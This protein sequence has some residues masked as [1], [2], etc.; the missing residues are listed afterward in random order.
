MLIENKTNT[1]S[2]QKPWKARVPKIKCDVFYGWT[3][4]PLTD[5]NLAVRPLDI[6]AILLSPVK[7]CWQ[8]Y[9]A[10]NTNINCNL[11]L[12]Q[13]FILGLANKKKT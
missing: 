9:A 11:I 3:N 7:L 5:S 2:M 12:P 10:A 6:T 4:D 13:E 1:K 8:H